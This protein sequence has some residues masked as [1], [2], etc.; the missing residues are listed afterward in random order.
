MS[1]PKMPNDPMPE[2]KQFE[3][4]SRAYREALPGDWATP[5]NL[6]AHPFA[7]AAAMGAI[8]CAMAGHAMGVW[9]GT[10]AGMAE[11]S[12]R[13]WPVAGDSAPAS[14]DAATPAM[15]KPPKL[16]LVRQTRQ[17]DAAEAAMRDVVADARRTAKDVAK[18]SHEVADDMLDEALAKTR[19]AK[20]ARARVAAKADGPSKPKGIDKPSSPDDLKLISGVG[21]KLEQVLNSY[22][23]WTYAQI[24]DLAESEVAWLD[25]EL[26]FGGRIGR[27]DWLGQAGRLRDGKS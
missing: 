11:A 4:L 26:G 24:A 13:A 21:P 5:F 9:A 10:F 22:G 2:S 12:R 18:V 8:G 17:V 19:P 27:D 20:Q 1:T 3:D 6:M 16:E 25:G 14:R 7:G 23:I 15:S